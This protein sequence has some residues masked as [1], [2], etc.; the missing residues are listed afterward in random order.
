[1]RSLPFRDSILTWLLR[2]ALTA[3]NS[4]VTVL[5]SI[6]PAEDAYDETLHVLKY[7]ERL[8]PLV[9]CVDSDT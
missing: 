4:K 3:P 1:M 5:A 7:A 9:R 8:G 6:S 2:V